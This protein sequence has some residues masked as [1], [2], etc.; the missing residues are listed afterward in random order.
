MNLK[1]VVPTLILLVCLVCIAI[2]KVNASEIV[3][4]AGAGRANSIVVK[5]FGSDLKKAGAPAT[6]VESVRVLAEL[7]RVLDKETRDEA[8]ISIADAIVRSWK[9]NDWN[10]PLARDMIKIG[11]VDPRAMALGII[12]GVSD[13]DSSSVIDVT[14]LSRQLMLSR[15]DYGGVSAYPPQCEG[16]SRI[17]QGRSQVVISGFSREI[18]WFQCSDAEVLLFLPE[19]GFFSKEEILSK[20]CSNSTGDIPPYCANEH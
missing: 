7:Y 16:R 13:L 2:S 8:E 1:S 17:A 5:E 18:Y 20:I 11:F 15:L 4:L 3:V 10:T 12:G 14:S 19:M 6:Y 9:L